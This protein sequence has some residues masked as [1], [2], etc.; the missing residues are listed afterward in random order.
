MDNRI[1]LFAAVLFA[2]S[3]FSYAASICNSGNDLSSSQKEISF[4]YSFSCPTGAL[5]VKIIDST[6]QPAAGIRIGLLDQTPPINE[7][8]YAQADSGGAASFTVP[9]GGDYFLF[10][11][12]YGACPGDGRF[13]PS[14]PDCTGKTAAMQ[15]QTAQNQSSGAGQIPG[16]N[17]SSEEGLQPSALSVIHPPQAL[18]RPGSAAYQESMNALDRLVSAQKTIGSAVATLGNTPSSEIESALHSLRRAQEEYARENYASSKQ[19]ADEAVSYAKGA[20]SP[21]NQTSSTIQNLGEPGTEAY[22]YFFWGGM[23]L[24]AMAAIWA[25]YKLIPKGALD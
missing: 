25:I 2:F 13:L 6:K 18:P 23:I 12:E 3:Q 21:K 16:G 1:I 19:Y 5:S 11:L 7:T 20:L 22:S 24:V 14:L 4:S 15:N 9:E 10:T 17:A 8:L